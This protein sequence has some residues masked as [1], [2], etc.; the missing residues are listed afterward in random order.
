MDVYGRVAWETLLAVCSR[1]EGDRERY[2]DLLIQYVE[3]S[4]CLYL[5]K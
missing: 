4:V 3:C 1:N 5:F 2:I